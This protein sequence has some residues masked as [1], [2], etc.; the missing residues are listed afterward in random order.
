LPERF[1]RLERRAWKRTELTRERGER[2]EFL[3]GAGAGTRAAVPEK[4]R[5]RVKSR[6]ESV[7]MKPL[8]AS[9][10]HPGGIICHMMLLP[11]AMRK[12]S[13]AG[14]APLTT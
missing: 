9:F 11:A 8:F 6:R 3:R 4:A 2:L 13:G 7:L 10:G 14:S 1:V 5:K 12:G